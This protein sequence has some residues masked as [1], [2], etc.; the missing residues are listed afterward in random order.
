MRRNVLAGQFGSGQILEFDPVTG[1]FKGWLYD[2]SNAP[3]TIDGLW[4]LSFGSGGISG[5]ATSLFFTAGP[6]GGQHGLFGTITAIENVL[7]GDL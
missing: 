4:G 3:L 1:R 7:G 6:D 5:P 2:T